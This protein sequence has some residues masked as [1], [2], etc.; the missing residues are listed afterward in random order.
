MGVL[1]AIAR[2]RQH[3]G[4]PVSVVT[5]ERSAYTVSGRVSRLVQV[6]SDI[7]EVLSAIRPAS[8]EGPLQRE[9]PEPGSK[10]KGGRNPVAYVLAPIGQ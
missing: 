8:T 5:F 7:A 3:S 2:V 6:L 9:P 1:G 10:S 4:A